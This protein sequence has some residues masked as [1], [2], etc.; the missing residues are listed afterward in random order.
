MEVIAMSF[1]P[2]VALML[3]L[4]M[5]VS[6]MAGYNTSL[7]SELPAFTVSVNS[8]EGDA[9]SAGINQTTAGDPVIHFDM[10]GQ[11][12]AI[13]DENAYLNDASGVYS[14]P[15]SEVLNLIASMQTIPEPTEEDL[16]ALLIFA[17]GVLGSISPTSFNLSMMSTGM[18]VTIDVDKLFDELDAGVPNVLTSYAQYLDP[19]LQKY[20]AALLGQTLTCADLA[21]AWPQLGLS[22]INTGLKAQL[23]VLQRGNQTTIIGSISDVNFMATVSSTGFKLDVTTPDGVT[24][25][26]DTA[27]VAV[28]AEILQGVLSGI[29]AEAFSYGTVTERDANRASVFT[30]TITLDT[31]AL[32]ND[33]NAAMAD[34]ITTNS[35]TVDTLLNK[36]RSWIALF[37]A[38]TASQLTAESLSQA[39]T[40]GLISLPAASGKLTVAEHVYT[41]TIIVDGSF[42]GVELTGK[43]NEREGSG[44]FALTYDDRYEP[45]MLTLDCYSYRDSMQFSFNSNISIFGLFRTLTLSVEDSYDLEW[46]LTTDT[47]VLRAGYSDEEQYMEAKI[48]PVNAKF[49][50]DEDDFYHLSFYSPVFFA[51]L[52]S[53]DSGFNLATTFGGL[54]YAESRYGFQLDGY[55]NDNDYRRSTF[56]LTSRDLY[57]K[58]TLSAYLY[59]SDGHDYTLGYDGSSMTLCLDGMTY[60]V[61]EIKTGRSDQIGLSL[62][63]PNLANPN[64]L[65]LLIT[66]TDTVLTADLYQGA[67]TTVTPYL[68]VSLDI[69]PAAMTL[70]TDVTTVDLNTFMNKLNSLF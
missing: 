68:S 60:I 13:T 22:E 51:D 63:S 30:T 46:S 64:I 70:P 53:S 21:S 55:V 35:D 1:S 28:L 37:D 59:T 27:D 29:T 4:S 8:S 48:G 38:S 34:A 15:V 61:K 66:A 54:N 41:N 45:L 18:S 43:L 14:V 10:N 47:N 5:L 12:L 26:L 31:T 69:D 52:H 19:T 6:P 7:V 67:D 40:N 49:H 20:S 33:L 9:A 25:T 50:M 11:G 16:Q 56:G 65:T 57:S 2:L 3:V 42:A 36:Y 44:T 62:T 17:Q 58:E 32:A 39:F 24:Y 23:T